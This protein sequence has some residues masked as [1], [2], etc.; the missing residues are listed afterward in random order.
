MVTKR[1]RL[2]EQGP[3]C[4]TSERDRTH[5]RVPNPSLYSN[6]PMVWDFLELI[7]NDWKRQTATFQD[8]INDAQPEGEQVY[9]SSKAFIE[10]Q[11]YFLKCLFSYVMF[12]VALDNAY[13]LFYQELNQLNRKPFLRVSHDKPPKANI[14]IEKVRFIRNVSIVHL[15][16]DKVRPIDALAAM[17]WQPLVWGKNQDEDWNID[18]ITFGGAKLVI[19]DSSGNVAGQAVDLEIA[20]IPE[21]HMACLDYLDEYDRVCSEYLDEILKKLPI[22]YNETRYYR[23]K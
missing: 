9:H 19:H 7:V 11:P 20:G 21:L 10:L 23:F 15:G 2:I 22:T 13:G 12:F 16:S 14:Y 6:I 4:A 5:E 8:A 1:C 18:K 17:M 3:I